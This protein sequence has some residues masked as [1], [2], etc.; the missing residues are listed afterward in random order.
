MDTPRTLYDCQQHGHTIRVL[1]LTKEEKE[2]YQS[3]HPGIVCVPM[4]CLPLTD[5][6]DH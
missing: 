6:K 5:E 1:M 4:H 2:R 3:A